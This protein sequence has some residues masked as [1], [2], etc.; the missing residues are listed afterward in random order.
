MVWVARDPSASSRTS[1]ATPAFRTTATTPAAGAARVP[2]RESPDA[3]DSREW[4][5]Y[6]GLMTGA[7][8]PFAVEGPKVSSYLA[9]GNHDNLSQGSQETIRFFEDFPTGRFK[10]LLTEPPTVTATA[11]GKSDFSD[12]LPRF[13]DA[14]KES[15]DRPRL[16]DRP[17]AQAITY[18][19]ALIIPRDENCQDVNE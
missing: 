4:P 10:S 6:R 17:R 16:G 19:R 15:Y 7:Q 5:R 2:R 13:A 12:R 1:V 9:F 3:Y 11:L 18:D 8:Q 14:F